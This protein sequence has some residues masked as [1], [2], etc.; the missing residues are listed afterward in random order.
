MQ[1]CSSL[2]QHGAK[3]SFEAGAGACSSNIGK[4]HVSTVYPRISFYCGNFHQMAL[5]SETYQS[6]CLLCVLGERYGQCCDFDINI[7]PTCSWSNTFP[8]MSVPGYS[9]SVVHDG[10]LALGKHRTL[11]WTSTIIDLFQVL[12]MALNVMLVFN[13]TCDIRRLRRLEKWYLLFSYGV[14]FVPCL[15]YIFL[16]R[17]GKRRILGGATVSTIS[18]SMSNQILISSRSGVGLILVSNGCAL[19]SSMLL[20]GS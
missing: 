5:F 9:Y 19:H 15:A 12:C 4:E 1:I 17:V 13:S 7:R 6:T 3:G 8:F 14:P 16:D 18:L 10:R 11:Y 20:F 2:Y